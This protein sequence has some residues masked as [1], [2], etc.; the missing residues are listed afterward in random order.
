M[1]NVEEQLR[2][3][4]AAATS[5]VV[6]TESDLRSARTSV[7]TRNETREHRGR[8]RTLLAAAAAVVV[9]GAIGFTAVQ[10]LSEDDTTSTPASGGQKPDAFPDFLTGDAP[11]VENL[12][13]FWRVDNGTS[14]VRFQQDGTV[15]F[16]DQGAVISDPVTVGT[17]SID[18]DE[19]TIRVTS[20]PK[21]VGEG[22]TMRA[23]L[24]EPGITHIVLPEP[25]FGTCGSV[26]TTIALEHVVPTDSPLEGLRAPF[27]E[28]RWSTVQREQVLLGDWMAEGGGYL[29]EI[30]EDG[31]YYVVDGSAEVVDTGR[32]R[33]RSS[34]LELFSRTESPQCAEGDWLRLGN[35][36]QASVGTTVIRGTVDQNDCGGKWTPESW[37]R[38]PDNSPSNASG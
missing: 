5:G 29:L 26:A 10:A 22:W 14:M 13:G 21:C 2:Q 23:A 16:S 19:V 30:A 33:L 8:N 18:G 15:Q 6:V 3:D 12:S 37:I 34:M 38:I 27:S 1:T 20:G 24:A 28:R 17:Y 32:W 36:Q 7:Q 9:V 25:R 4:I 31:T 35:L 11:T